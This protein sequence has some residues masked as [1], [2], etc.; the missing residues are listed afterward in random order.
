MRSQGQWLSS[1]Q[2]VNTGVNAQVLCW[3]VVLF[4]FGHMWSANSGWQSMSNPP[5]PL[6]L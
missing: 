6:L 4:A 3:T 2:S 1:Y 5:P